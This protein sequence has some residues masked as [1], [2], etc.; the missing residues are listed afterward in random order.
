MHNSVQTFFHPGSY[1]KSGKQTYYVFLASYALRSKVL[2]SVMFKKIWGPKSG[3]NLY[4]IRI[5]GVKKH[6][7]PDPQH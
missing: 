4:R 6:R 7:I 5:Q 1:M 2:V 3:K